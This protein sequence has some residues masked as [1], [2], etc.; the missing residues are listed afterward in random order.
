MK[1]LLFVLIPLNMLGQDTFPLKE[2]KVYYEQVD[3]IPGISQEKIFSRAM[4][5]VANSFNNSNVVN[6]LE[7][8]VE[9]EY[10]GKGSTDFDMPGA[11]VSQTGKIRFTFRISA[12][13]EKLRLQI[14]DLEIADNLYQFI[15]NIK[16]YKT[17]IKKRNH[18]KFVTF[19]N[20]IAP[21][22]Q[23]DMVAFIQKSEDNF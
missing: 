9:G 22:L 1:F 13:D 7:N 3:S 8:T 23:A 2:G 14:Y 15:Y 10:L 18:E 6:R 17:V 19:V 11:I 12:R 20:K 21:T 5:W 4:L 16:D